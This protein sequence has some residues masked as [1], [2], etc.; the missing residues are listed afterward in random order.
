MS[1]T[2][3]LIGIVLGIIIGVVAVILFVFYGAESTIDNAAL[4]ERGEQNRP[5][6]EG[7]AAPGRDR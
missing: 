3:R 4:D 7:P 2:D 1:W 6:L 5:Q